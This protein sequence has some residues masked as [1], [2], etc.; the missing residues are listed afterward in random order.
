MATA[1][2]P[3]CRICR[4]VG[5]F[6]F[7]EEQGLLVCSV[8][9]FQSHDFRDEQTEQAKGVLSIGG[10]K[11]QR[12][13]PRQSEE[14]RQKLKEIAA[15][16]DAENS[17]PETS[18]EED[19]RMYNEGFQL[20]M[21]MQLDALVQ[22]FNVPEAVRE[23]A[24]DIWFRYLE[25][26]AGHGARLSDIIHLVDDKSNMYRVGSA[27]PHRR[28]ARR[29]EEGEGDGEEGGEDDTAAVDEEGE[30]V[31][32]GGERDGEE[33]PTAVP[34]EGA[35]EEEREDGE[36]EAGEAGDAA[37]SGEEAALAVQ[38]DEAGEAPAARLRGPA[39]ETGRFA[40]SQRRAIACANPA[41]ARALADA[42]G[43]K[44]SGRGGRKR[45]RGARGASAE[46]GDSEG[47]E[48]E[49]AR[50][51]AG[52]GEGGGD[53]EEAAVPAGAA[54]AA[55]DVAP[56]QLAVAVYGPRALRP[57]K[58]GAQ[59]RGRTGKE[60]R[61]ARHFLHGPAWTLAICF[62]ACAWLREP[63]LPIDFVRWARAGELPYL[64]AYRRLPAGLR[65]GRCLL[66]D[67]AAACP[68]CGSWRTRWACCAISAAS[69]SPDPAL[70]LLFRLAHTTRLPGAVAAVAAKLLDLVDLRLPPNTKRPQARPAPTRLPA[71]G[72]GPQLEAFIRFAAPPAPAPPPPPP[73]K[74][75][76]P[77]AAGLEESAAE[78][79]A[80]AEPPR[81]ETCRGWGVAAA[82][83]VAAKLI[84]ALDDDPAALARPAPLG[85][86]HLSPWAT[87]ASGQLARWARPDP[88]G[89][90]PWSPAEARALEP[91]EV[92]A[93]VRFCLEHVLPPPRDEA[94]PPPSDP[95][96]P[97]PSA[98]G[99]PPAGETATHVTRA[100]QDVAHLLERLA[101]AAPAA[102]PGDP[103]Q[104]PELAPPERVEGQGAGAGPRL[105]RGYVMYGQTAGG[106]FHRSYAITL[107]AVAEAVGADAI[108]L[109]QSVRSVEEQLFATAGAL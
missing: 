76:Q 56:E 88:P 89:R 31:E 16:R 73:R 14:I 77:S 62:A 43:S 61:R 78:A 17:L 27:R 49:A 64:A 21:K 28:S 3:P 63:L 107:D 48:E 60:A 85:Q 23:C 6:E 35:A 103:A 7:K 82:L 38:E 74:G 44:F 59:Q 37:G 109:H 30:A 75:K 5:T 47:V 71:T 22:R 81:E 45:K 4:Q 32:D 90:I 36:H 1:A 13:E 98:E 68:G 39:P 33:L 55:L 58:R 42:V 26:S 97:A 92:P 54:A 46:A 100:I 41:T 99:P 9:G 40:R 101:R 12:R 51:L 108:S 102:P 65:V 94:A 8:C 86:L 57:R 10:Q 52:R 83:L 70:P 87:W 50:A 66:N 53:E 15:Q 105:G 67:P 34:A 20:I 19:A 2:Q 79:A 93:Y 95:D 18:P 80:G 29:G 69:R 84:Y 25:V 24:G 106:V 91:H 11:T 72:D 104:P 96:A